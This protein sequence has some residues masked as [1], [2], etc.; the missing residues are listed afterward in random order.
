M[1][2][3]TTEHFAVVTIMDEDTVSDDLV[4]EGQVALYDIFN[5][6]RKTITTNLLYKNKQAGTV[7][8]E[9]TWKPDEELREGKVYVRAIEAKLER[10]TDLIGK[11]DCFA[12]IKIG[13]NLQK[14][15]VCK[16]SGKFPKWNNPRFE[17]ER[18]SEYQ[19]TVQVWDEDITSNDLVGEATFSLFEVF[20]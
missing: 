14:T 13:D 8:L 12:A 15:S 18:K 19:A 17:F 9:C 1:L 3:R 10:D 4:G 11:M 5:K 16:N 6:G 7:T 2:R 20:Q